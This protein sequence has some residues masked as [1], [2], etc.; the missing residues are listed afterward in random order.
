MGTSIGLLAQEIART[1]RWWRETD[2]WKRDPDLVD[3]RNLNLAYRA[4][5]LDELEDGGLYILR[6]ARRVGKT[7]A[8]KQAVRSLIDRGIPASNV[9][10]VAVDGWKAPDLRTLV[11]NSALPLIGEGERR[12]WF[13]D[14]I[15][16][17]TG[18]WA[19][20][21]KWLR[22]NEP[23]FRNATVVL[24]GSNADGLSEAVGVLAGRRGQVKNSD[25]TLLPI[26]FRSFVHELHPEVVAAQIEAVE[27][28]DLHDSALKP[29]LNGMLAWMDVLVTSFERYISYGGFPV[30]VSDCKQGRPIS[31]WF[32]EAI[33]DV[34]YREAF[35]AARLSEMETASVLAR[36]SRG[37]AS[38]FNS[39]T[40]GNDVGIGRDSMSRRVSD[41]RDSYYLW[42]CSQRAD[43]GWAPRERAQDKLYFIDPVVSNLTHLRN[44][45][46][47]P[48]EPTAL[49][50]QQLGM[51][52]RRHIEARF[53]GRWAEHDQLFYYRTPARKEVDFVGRL[54]DRVAIE[55]KYT[56]SGSW[57]GEARTVDASSFDGIVA[58]R[59]VLDTTRDGRSWAIP[60]AF[61]AYLIDT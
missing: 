14:E 33:F 4:K 16:G 45:D 58:T 57:V 22:D 25:R 3:A 20:Q 56:Q 12:W 29:R 55:G 39:T 41:L 49:V 38:P 26:G 50:E 37:L 48:C 27:V 23:T 54:M 7:V 9:V 21:I 43:G 60:A 52:L 46:W 28:E 36:I 35:A 19:S 34:I 17:V 40:G 2:W 32:I 59:N 18:D 30:S 31:E 47:A 11:Q 8:V 61:I 42:P 24:T 44:G 1:N 51:A 6:G 13:I 5:C 15:T 10:A 53:P